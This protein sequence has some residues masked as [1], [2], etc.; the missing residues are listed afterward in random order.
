[1]QLILKKKHKFLCHKHT[2]RVF[3][4][5]ELAC[6]LGMW[7]E[8]LES[9]GVNMEEGTLAFLQFV[10]EDLQTILKGLFV[11]SSML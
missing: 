1:M 5:S 11:G 4:P 8:V 9:V 2:C 7:R 3:I 6:I 10:F